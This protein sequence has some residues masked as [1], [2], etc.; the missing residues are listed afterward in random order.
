MHK[1]FTCSYQ[2]FQGQVHAINFVHNFFSCFRIFI[3]LVA[4]SCWKR[5]FISIKMNHGWTP[6]DLDWTV[7]QKPSFGSSSMINFSFCRVPNIKF[8]VAKVLQSLIP[9]VDQP[10]SKLHGMLS[11]HSVLTD[12]IRFNIYHN[13][14]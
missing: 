12:T 5:Q 2:F 7:L 1:A 10:V 14:G 6:V 4:H 13:I 3:I 9:I 11:C 8:N